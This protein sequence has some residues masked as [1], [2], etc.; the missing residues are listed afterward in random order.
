MSEENAKATYFLASMN[1]AK[2]SSN[3]NVIEIGFRIR[4]LKL[5]R[6]GAKSNN[7]IIPTEKSINSENS[8][9]SSSALKAK[10]FKRS[11]KRDKNANITTVP[12][13]AML[14]VFV[15]PKKNCDFVDNDNEMDI[16][17]FNELYRSEIQTQSEMPTFSSVLLLPIQENLLNELYAKQSM[18]PAEEFDMTLRFEVWVTQRA[19]DKGIGKF[20]LYGYAMES[21]SSILKKSGF[22]SSSTQN[23][24]SKIPC[25]E[26][27]CTHR[28]AFCPP[29]K[30]IFFGSNS[31]L[32]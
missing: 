9:R 26:T 27:M 24:G 3:E 7:I 17:G 32:L 19:Q 16:D 2:F 5:Q 22:V 23:L 14:K 11:K 4:N 28:I 25:P 6:H 29:R 1:Q 15:Y 12:F 13:L 8:K 21:L 31:S 10:L 18:P 20:V 30:I